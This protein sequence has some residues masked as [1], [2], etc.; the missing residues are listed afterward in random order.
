MSAQSVQGSKYS[1]PAERLGAHVALLL[2]AQSKDGT[3]QL[4]AFE[5]W[6]N[7]LRTLNLNSFYRHGLLGAYGEPN[8]DSEQ[9]AQSWFDL[10]FDRALMVQ[11]KRPTHKGHQLFERLCRRAVGWPNLSLERRLDD[12]GASAPPEICAAVF[13]RL[14]YLS[15][16]QSL[17]A[18]MAKLGYLM[19]IVEDAKVIVP[20]GL[21]L[22]SAMR[23][24]PARLKHLD[25]EQELEF[26]R[27]M[28]RAVH[29]ANKHW[30][31]LKA[32]ALNPPHWIDVVDDRVPFASLTV[33]QARLA[34]K[35]MKTA[36]G[37][38]VG[39]FPSRTDFEAAWDEAPISKTVP[40]QTFADSPVGR[41]LMSSSHV[42]HVQTFEDISE[43]AINVPEPPIGAAQD[44]LRAIDELELSRKFS[45]SEL[46]IVR[47][48]FAGAS[49]DEIYRSRSDLKQRFACLDDFIEHS[50]KLSSQLALAVLE[51]ETVL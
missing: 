4:N 31:M 12:V 25:S 45:G 27:F 32:L 10:V 49:L 3:T 28:A 29:G 19:L 13:D 20:E 1:R 21:S 40:F 9:K 47:S 30:E 16:D 35:F 38:C 37:L 15:G 22:W 11:G 8:Q 43:T 34:V 6:T 2:N 23:A 36:F 7:L 5:M 14:G 39:T 24:G 42:I 26:I 51:M 17:P 44:A 50:D 46:D 41:E 48:V 33:N 18:S